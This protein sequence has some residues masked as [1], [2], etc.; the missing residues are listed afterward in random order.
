MDTSSATGRTADPPAAAAGRRRD[1]DV[2]RARIVK[3]AGEVFAASGFDGATLQLIASRAQS[4]VPL[5]VYHFKTKHDLWL[6]VV[7]D[8]IEPTQTKLDRA[9]AL[10]DLT[11]GDRVREV[12]RLMIEML[13]AQPQIHRIISIDSYETTARLTW[14][15]ETH[16]ERLYAR[17]TALL[18][19]AQAEGVVRDLDPARLRYAILGVVALPAVAAEYRAMTGRD[20]TAP[21]ELQ[22]SLDFLIRLIFKD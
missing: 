3:A 4:S 7:E 8:L 5:L 9:I 16:V 2:V 18:R 22:G 14:L 19:D 12:L 13:A 21:E 1:A 11:A 20:A 10:P 15:F 17:F 6:A